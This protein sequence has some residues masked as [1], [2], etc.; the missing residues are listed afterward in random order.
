MATE[1]IQLDTQDFST[2]IY[3]SQ[4]TNLI[5]TFDIDTSLS[6]SSYIELFI[7]DNNKNILKSEYNFS[8]FSVLN[9]G[10]ASSTNSLSQIILNPENI[11]TQLNYDQGE[12]ITYF[13][14]LNKQIGSNIESLYI[15]EI[16][17]DRTEVRLD[18]TVLSNLDIFEKTNTFIQE[19]SNSLY[20]LD[21][22]LNFG[23]NNLL[24]SNN[25]ILD[26][27]DPTNY[28]ILIK[29]YEPLPP[30]YDINSTLWVV[31]SVEESLAYKVTFENLPIVFNDA[32]PIQGPN[33]N[34]DLQ[35]QVNNS[36]IELSYVDLIST[37]LT[38]SQNQ[39]NS[40]LEEKELDINVDYTDFTN[41]IHF[42]SAQT[43]IENFYYKVGLIENYSS[44]ISILNSTISSSTNVSESQAVLENKIS[45]IITNFDGYE[46]YLYYTDTPYSYPKSNTEP[47]F[48]L[49]STSSVL[50]GDA[51]TLPT[52]V[53]LPSP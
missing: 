19:R 36:T 35:D 2:Q 47:P 53:T 41:F 33:F 22:Y 14:F 18:S 9:D 23:E 37:N 17:S 10:Q 1:I 27:E 49:E 46:Y 6:S 42:S 5:S 24:I 31:S 21:F 52:P 8:N 50:V 39:L 4:D 43:R 13:N 30:E 20:F 48:I 51:V 40:L 7:Y 32:I 11:L 16:S 25:I 34:L 12:Y 44:S 28:T 29:L 26:D 3:G 15:A 45:N 38:S